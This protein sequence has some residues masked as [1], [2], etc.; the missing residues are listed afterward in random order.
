MPE[1]PIILLPPST[2]LAVF[3]CCLQFYHACSLH[4]DSS[5]GDLRMKSPRHL[6]TNKT[7]TILVLRR[8]TPLPKTS[9]EGKLYEDPT[10]TPSPF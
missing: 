9:A 3:N 4:K 1:L 5:L 6:Y 8:D 2:H 10:Y 7:L